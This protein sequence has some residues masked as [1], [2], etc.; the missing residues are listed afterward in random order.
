MPAQDIAALT[1]ELRALR[2]TDDNDCILRAAQSA[3]T[4]EYATIPPYLTAMWSIKETRDPVRETLRSIVLEEM[5][6]MGLVCNLLSGLGGYPDFTTVVPTYP[7]QLPA[8]VQPDLIVKLTRLTCAQLA[9]FMTIEYP[10][11]EPIGVSETGM[12]T[13][14]GEFYEQLILAIERVN[15][16]LST[17]KQ[18]HLW[19]GSNELF[20]LRDLA[21]V[22]RAIDTIR[23]QGEGSAESPEEAEGQ[24]A[25]FYQFREVFVG[26]KFVHDERSNTWSHCGE[27]VELPEVWPMADIPLGGYTMIQDPQVARLLESFDDTYSRM[28]RELERVWQDPNAPFGTRDAGDPILTMLALESEAVAL[29]QKVRPDRRGNYGPCFRYRA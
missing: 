28:L 14:I 25:H 12:A 16:S 6:H 22:R 29:M 10:S 8:N 19:I 24:L 27:I 20:E 2:A 23:K 26:C 13:T 3:I 17:E 4:L 9:N 21:D 1:Q 7:G 5:L 15:P 11:S 18:R